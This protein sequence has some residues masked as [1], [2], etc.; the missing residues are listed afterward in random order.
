MVG[1]ISLQEAMMLYLLEERGYRRDTLQTGTGIPKNNLTRD[2]F[3]KKGQT[4]LCM[5]LSRVRAENETR[6]RDL[7]ITNASLYQL[8]YF[9]NLYL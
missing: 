9:G 7:R 6:T 5:K 1:I 2:S 4:S 8:S 3:I